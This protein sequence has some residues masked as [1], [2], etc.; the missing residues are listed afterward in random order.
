MKW[1]L[2]IICILALNTYTME[3][4][5]NSSDENPAKNL[6]RENY[7]VYEVEY[8]NLPHKNKGYLYEHLFLQTG[9][10]HSSLAIGNGS[11]KIVSSLELKEE[12]VP[13]YAQEALL[14][15]YKK[16][17]HE[18]N[19][20]RFEQAIIERLGEYS[21]QS[22]PIKKHT[23]VSFVTTPKSKLKNIYRS[24]ETQTES[25][26]FLQFNPKSTKSAP[27][28]SPTKIDRKPLSW[29]QRNIKT[30]IGIAAV[31]GCLATLAFQWGIKK[32]PNWQ[33]ALFT[34]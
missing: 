10:E 6:L 5:K 16:E 3:L 4:Q 28:P 15:T 19:L 9:N 24:I 14:I 12:E 7:H 33:S 25:F 22:P 1:Y 17:T 32:M 26:A 23:S 2:I 30:I 20:V 34:K 8:K 11:L 13:L 31:S 18:L 21:P 29:A 27:K